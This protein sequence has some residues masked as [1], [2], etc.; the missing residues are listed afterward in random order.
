MVYRSWF[1]AQGSWPGGLAWPWSPDEP[2]A[3]NKQPIINS[4]INT[5]PSTGQYLATKYQ[6]VPNKFAR[7]SRVHVVMPNSITRTSRAP[8]LKQGIAGLSMCQVAN[9]LEEII[10]KHRVG[11][12]L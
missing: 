11:S 4:S 1:T 9:A 7:T 12:F 10:R 5:L 3:I 6:T 8:W 2:W